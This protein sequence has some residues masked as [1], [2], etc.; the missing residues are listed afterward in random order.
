MKLYPGKMAFPIP[1]NKKFLRSIDFLLGVY[2]MENTR[3]ASDYDVAKTFGI[4]K[5][6]TTITMH[7]NQ[8][9]PQFPNGRVLCNTQDESGSFTGSFL[10]IG[11]STN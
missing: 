10:K 2:S 1:P 5:F 4:Q 9:E 8:K 3:Y 7:R 6:T 11:I